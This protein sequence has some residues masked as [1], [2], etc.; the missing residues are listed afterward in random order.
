MPVATFRFDDILAEAAPVPVAAPIGTPVSVVRSRSITSAQGTSRAGAWECS[1]GRWRR[2]VLQAEF[3]HFLEG[4][5]IFTPDAGDP[6]RLRAG[7]TAYFPA[8][9]TGVWDVIERSR[10]VFLIFDEGEEA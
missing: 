10:K 3:C 1:P 5:A 7:D 4:E 6:V 2:Q 9:S 8:G